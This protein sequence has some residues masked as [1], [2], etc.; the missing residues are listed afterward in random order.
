[1]EGCVCDRGGD[2]EL[3]TTATTPKSGTE[4]K[5]EFLKGKEKEPRYKGKETFRKENAAKQNWCEGVG[6]AGKTHTSSEH[7]NPGELRKAG[8]KE[9]VKS[10]DNPGQVETGKGTEQSQLRQ[11]K[12]PYGIETDKGE[13]K[14]KKKSPRS[15]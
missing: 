8:G 7:V 15:R 6:G 13:Q 10:S 4:V 3:I 9:P 2:G 12:L 5:K 1:V 11:E 14:G